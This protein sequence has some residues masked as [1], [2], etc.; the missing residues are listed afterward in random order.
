MT[1][2]THQTAPIRFVEANG[3]RFAY[4]RFDKAGGGLPRVCNQHNTG[5]MDYWDPAVTDGLAKTREVSLFNNAA[6]SSSSG[7]VP[8][9][10]REIGGDAI[11]FIKALDLTKADMLGFSI[12]GMVA[13]KIATPNSTRSRRHKSRR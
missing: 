6:V 4:R 9:L 3:I 8:T 10:F 1:T 13:Q 2:H 12:G 11:A 7:E 5:T